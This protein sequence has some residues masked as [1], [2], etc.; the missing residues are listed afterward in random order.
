MTACIRLVSLAYPWLNGCL[1][2]SW[3]AAYVGLTYISLI[4]YAVFTLP[5]KNTPQGFQHSS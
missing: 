3:L 1:I 5:S 2:M 4:I